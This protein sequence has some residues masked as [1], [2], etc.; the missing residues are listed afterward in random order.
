MQER[1]L[2]LVSTLDAILKQVGRIQKMITQVQIVYT[3]SRTNENEALV[4]ARR[5]YEV[6]R[7]RDRAFGKAELFGEPSW[8]MLVDLFIA[9][10]EGRRLTAAELCSVAGAPF[11]TAYRWL[12][13]MESQGLVVRLFS[14]NDPKESGIII[15]AQARQDMKVFFMS[16]TAL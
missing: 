13:L 8:D 3:A 11:H 1:N 7:Y 5:H 15:S 12:A 9:I 6:R 16:L 2:F 14:E 10:E 4:N